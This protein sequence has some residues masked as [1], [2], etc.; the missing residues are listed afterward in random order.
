MRNVIWPTIF[1]ATLLAGCA[2]AQTR[3]IQVVIAS[4][5]AAD[6]TA[7]GYKSFVR[8]R[9]A[10]CDAKMDPAKNTKAEAEEC[11]GLASPENGKRLSQV[12]SGLVAAQTAVKIAVEC[13]TNPLKLPV[14]FRV[15]CVDAKKADWNQ[16]AEA[17]S[18]AWDKM[19]PY[20][21]AVKGV[22]P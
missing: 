17:V 12:V 5:G 3:A 19:R 20:F 9:V 4:D 1:C 13:G 8:Q 21:E 10:E 2:S 16:L 11:L 6:A 7:A 14:E 18:D 15:Q 22:T